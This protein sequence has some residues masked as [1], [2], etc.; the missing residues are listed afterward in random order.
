[1]GEL[2]CLPIRRSTDGP[3]FGA[4]NGTVTTTTNFRLRPEGY[5]EFRGGFDDLKPLGGTGADAISAGAYSAVHQVSS[6]Y[7]WVRTYDESQASGSEFSSNL[8]LHAGAWVA[9]T[10]T[11]D[12][13]YC[14]DDREF[15]RIGCSLSVVGAGIT[16]VYE[17][18]N[19][20]T[21]SALTTAETINW[22]TI[23]RSSTFASWTLPTDWTASTVGDSGTGNVLKKWMRIRC[24]AFGTAPRVGRFEIYGSGG[25]ELYQFTQS[26]RTSA[27]S[28]AL[29]RRGQSGTTAENF[30]V[31][32]SLYSS[33]DSDVSACSYRGR[34]IYVNGKETKRYDGS[35]HEDLGGVPFT[36]LVGTHNLTNQ[37]GGVLG[38]GIWRYYVAHGYGPCLNTDAYADRQDVKAM[39]GPGRA[40]Y[41]VEVTTLAAQRTR[42]EFAGYA[43][44]P[45]VSS[46]YIYRTDD[47]TNVA[48]ADR[49]S[50]PAFLIQSL[51]VQDTQWEQGIGGVGN[52]Y[53]DDSL[54]FV[55]P[56]QEAVVYDNAPPQR[57]RYSMVY[58]NRL[59][60]G[61]LETWYISDPFFPDSFRTKDTTGYIRL[62]RATGGRNMG[63][64]EF[65][66]QAV[67]YT[68]DQ[69]WGLTN[70]DLDVPQLF[71]IHPFVGNIAPKST[72]AGDGLLLWAA[73]D[74]IY[75]WD[76]D[77]R[78][79]PKKVSDD[80]DAAFGKMSYETHG[81]SRAVVR[82]R[83]YLISIAA[84]GSTPTAHYCLDLDS[85]QWS[86]W[87]PPTTAIAPL[88]T[89]YAPIGNEDEGKI[90]A[91]WGKVDYGT[92]A[93]EY[94]LLVDE[95]GTDDNGSTYNGACTFFF[96]Q[97]P[98]STFTPQ[99]II[100]YYQASS[101]W[102]TPS[103]SYS[104]AELGS[105]PG[106]IGTNT[107][108]TTA[109]YSVVS[110]VFSSI[111][112]GSHSLQVT[113]SVASS[114]GGAVNGQRLFGALLQ[115]TPQGF[116][117]GGP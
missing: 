113:F 114:A 32:T 39:Y 43:I 44:Q 31:A 115:G 26:P 71:P 56:Y 4:K 88:A 37:P 21:W 11:L 61:D 16:V 73:R 25:R 35:T 101:G 108:D 17:Y 5:L 14:G 66:D 107:P 75:A 1:M 38:A 111:N 92:G 63:G 65:A 41:T 77:G 48:A 49:A 20:S 95:L 64:V 40:A 87:Q 18:W 83:A 34:L 19:G 54:S 60:L 36:Y 76:G 8:I 68:E 9:F 80:W 91:I 28:G 98:G 97:D 86:P 59:L 30:A 106:T 89:V 72:A 13:I 100:A 51:R 47:L 104:G 45:G 74:G 10:A 112:R 82:D 29:Y 69:T 84:P 12:A 94:T 33:F 52:Y 6:P 102:A 105:S 23:L 99:K 22:T 81:G 70:V 67:L 7:G 3:L 42:I 116:R 85:M 27:T 78:N 110:G 57:C 58:Q 103:F 62:T 55:S 50:A 96:P 90:H 2:N 117:R 93:G 24:T 79:L 53:Y 46:I 15:S 109:T